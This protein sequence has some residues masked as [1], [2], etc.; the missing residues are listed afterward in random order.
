MV[1]GQLL[2]KLIKESKGFMSKHF[3]RKI[4]LAISK[5]LVETSITPNQMT[6]ISVSIGLIGA[7]LIEINFIFRQKRFGHSD[8]HLEVSIT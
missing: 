7:L 1:D 3:E 2:K 5:R 8:F 6:L 4:S